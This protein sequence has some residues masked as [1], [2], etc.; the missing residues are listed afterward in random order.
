MIED[1]LFTSP[2]EKKSYFDTLK[3]SFPMISGFLLIV[4]GFITIY[5][6][7]IILTVDYNTLEQL[8]NSPYLQ[9]YADYITVQ[10]LKNVYVMC[11]S[12]TF[13]ISIFSI[14]AGLCSIKKKM[15]PIVIIGA[16]L[17][18]FT[19]LYVFPVVIFIIALILLII[20]R[21]EFQ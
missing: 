5:F 10:Q 2:N 9:Q 1:D 3:P 15:Y 19:V 12:I 17:G 14:L 20:G 13:A 7:L 21:K 8:I 18:L 11:G 4:G 6:S 16:I